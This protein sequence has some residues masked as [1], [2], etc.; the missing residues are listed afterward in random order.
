[1]N[2]YSVCISA[3][4][5]RALLMARQDQWFLFY[6]GFLTR[7]SYCSLGR[8]LRGFTPVLMVIV[9]SQPI[10]HFSSITKIPIH[11]LKRKTFIS[12][13]AEGME[14]VSKRSFMRDF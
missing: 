10:K 4:P 12:S 3:L 6:C 11:I 14:T 5:I 1:V 9:L 2:F 7:A 8:S 13:L